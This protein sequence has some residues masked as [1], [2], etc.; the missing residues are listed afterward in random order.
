MHATPVRE[1]AV[2]YIIGL[3]MVLSFGFPLQAQIPGPDT[4][5]SAT[6]ATEKP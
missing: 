5:S 1:V 6:A 4:V 2:K 3:L